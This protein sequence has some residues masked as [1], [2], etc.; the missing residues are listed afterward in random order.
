MHESK[1]FFEK[2]GRQLLS[3]DM[4]IALQQLTTLKLERSSTRRVCVSFWQEPRSRSRHIPWYALRFSALFLPK[5]T[6]KFMTEYLRDTTLA[7]FIH[8][9]VN[10]MRKG[11]GFRLLAERYEKS[12]HIVNM[13][14]FFVNDLR[15][16]NCA[17][18]REIMN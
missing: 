16:R 6:H 5:N 13:A 4:N 1:E 10:E 11:L 17:G 9:I 18:R 2:S 14:E 12:R 8:K 3:R 7:W 15:S